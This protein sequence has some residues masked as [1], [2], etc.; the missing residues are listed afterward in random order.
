MCRSIRN[1]AGIITSVLLVSMLLITAGCGKSKDAGEKLNYEIKDVNGVKVFA[2]RNEPSVDKIDMNYVES[3]TINGDNEDEQKKFQIRQPV[4]DIDKNGNVYVIDINSSSIKKFDNKGEFAAQL[5]TKGTGP[6]EFFMPVS[7]TNANDT[8]YGFD[9]T[10]KVNKYD[11]SNN[12]ISAINLSQAEGLPVMMKRA[13]DYFVGYR[14]SNE[15]KDGKIFILFNLIVMDDHFKTIRTIAENKVEFDPSKPMNPLDMVTFFA[16]GKKEIA[17]ADKTSDRFRIKVYDLQ[18]NNIYDITK[19]FRKV[20]YSE[21]EIEKTNK[22]MAQALKNMPGQPEQK[23]DSQFKEA[24]TGMWYDKYGRLWVG[25]AVEDDGFEDFGKRSALDVFKDGVYL[26]KYT[27]ERP[28][29]MTAVDF[30]E[31]KLVFIDMEGNFIK[32]F[33]Y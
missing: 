23:I 25:T 14:V 20:K 30:V 33:E 10:M 22:L 16:A 27:F 15:Q 13:G 11:S 12:F 2:N 1:I 7:V 32:V 8:V 18:G 19:S 4:V 6:G 28:N 29:D 17:V 3:F 5:G 9:A 31:D 24:V 26:N 21:R